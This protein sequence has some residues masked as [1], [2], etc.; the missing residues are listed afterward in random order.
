MIS[1][2]IFY[3]TLLLCGILFASN[4]QDSNETETNDEELQDLIEEFRKYKFG[5]TNIIPNE[6]YADKSTVLKL[7]DEITKETT[8]EP[9]EEI[10]KETIEVKLD[11]KWSNETTEAKPNEELSK[12]TTE[13]KLDA[14]STNDAGDVVPDAD[15]ILANLDQDNKLEEMMK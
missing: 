6:E 8:E 2:N 1:V 4:A 3:F 10:L 15:N 9:E 5:G 14:E 11:E 12:D 13:Q 7:D